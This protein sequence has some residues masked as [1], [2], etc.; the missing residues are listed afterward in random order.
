M[1]LNNVCN[2]STYAHTLDVARHTAYG[3]HMHMGI[4]GCYVC[5]YAYPFAGRHQSDAAL[6]MRK[7]RFIR[8]REKK[9]CTLLVRT[10]RDVGCVSL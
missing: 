6:A 5:G 2:Y 4:V 10:Y 7:F 1:Y 3:L 9:G 8:E